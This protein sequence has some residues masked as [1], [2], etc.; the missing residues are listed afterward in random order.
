[1]SAMAFRNIYRDIFKMLNHSEHAPEMLAQLNS[2]EVINRLPL[3]LVLSVLSVI[4]IIANTHVLFV[5]GTKI[6]RSTYR[7]F[8][9]ALGCI[10]MLGCTISI[11]FQ[12]I[13]ETNPYTFN[14]PIACKIF[15]FFDTNLAIAAALMLVVIAAERFRKICR[16]NGKQVTEKRAIRS[17]IAVIIGSSI[18]TSP[19]LLIYGRHT[20]VI[21]SETNLNGSECS[22]SDA[23]SNS[24]YGYVYYALELLIVISCMVCLTILYSFVGKSL[25]AH[26]KRMKST[27]IVRFHVKNSV[28]SRKAQESTDS[29]TDE[30]LKVRE[31]IE[32]TQTDRD[33]GVDS[34]VPMS[35]DSL[36][37]LEIEIQIKDSKE[38]ESSS[39]IEDDDVFTNKE[40]N[41]RNNTESSGFSSTCQLCEGDE[42]SRKMSSIRYVFSKVANVPETLKGL[43]LNRRD[44]SERTPVTPDIIVT[45]CTNN[46]TKILSGSHED[47]VDEK[48]ETQG[49]ETN[50]SNKAIKTKKTRKPLKTFLRKRKKSKT[51][52][53]IRERRITKLLF[54]ITLTFI[55]TYYPYIIVL[56]IYAVRPEF[57]DN[58]SDVG[59]VF[60]LMAIRLYLINNVMN[61]FFYGMG[62]KVAV[63]TGANRGLGLELVRQLCKT[64][65]GDVILTSRMTDKGSAALNKLKVEGLR[66]RYHEL[67]ITQAASIRMFED[68]IKSE[69]GGIDVLINNAAV[70]YKKNELV[71][72][73]RQA[74][75]SI[76]TDFKGTLNVCRILLPHMHPHGRVVIITNGYI[77]KRKELGEKLQQELDLEKCN[78]YKLITLADEYM[79]AVKHGNH[80]SYGWPDSPIVLAKILLSALARVLTRE[81]AG[82]VRRNILINACCPGWMTSQGSEVYV[83]EDGT[84]QGIKPRPVEEA[85]KDVVWLATLPEGTKAPNGELVRY[86]EV[87]PFE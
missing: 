47:L 30:E 18:A 43:V 46:T 31:S 14:A 78:M 27:R 75:L 22:W 20:V 28:K 60:Y 61:A 17:I 79:K 11:P 86:R 73:F 81:L 5:F 62:R 10:D 12:I 84:C 52:E 87:I 38:K 35:S 2:E 19:A 76:E 48:N 51:A 26:N 80:K 33:S 1:M 37:S 70:T 71:P 82:D 56:I 8:V 9:L 41:D 36:E 68:F 39:T 23:V 3:L 13:D 45:D 77:G 57:K 40:S 25:R 24:Y 53:S 72:L 4:G 6:K 83:G 58:L 66:P 63:V 85:A 64:F 7:V 59:R 55:V 65:D 69:Y 29:K 50:E 15:R 32:S 74:Q 67:D 44:T 21:E 49:K 34:P 16:P 42:S 54:F